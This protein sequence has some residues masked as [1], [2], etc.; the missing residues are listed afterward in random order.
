MKEAIL[1]SE[2]KIDRRA[3]KTRKAIF[4]AL[5]ELLCEKEFRQITVQELSDRADVHRVTIYKHF[6]DIYDIYK[7]LEKL[8]LSEIGLLITQYGEKATFE[9]YPVFSN[10]SRI[11]Q[12]FSK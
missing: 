11:I 9:I 12:R 3:M 2:N 5:A 8:I 10:I 6:M 1:M 7:Q 4:E